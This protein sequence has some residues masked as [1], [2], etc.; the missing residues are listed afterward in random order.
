MEVS[1]HSGP[2]L[3]CQPVEHAITIPTAI[4]NLATPL[5]NFKDRQGQKAFECMFAMP[6]AT[7]S[8]R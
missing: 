3:F 4:V 1:G 2:A 5:R 7:R 6:R 8:G